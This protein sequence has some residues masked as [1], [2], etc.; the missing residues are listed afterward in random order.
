MK[1]VLLAC[2]QA[3]K[4]KLFENALRSLHYF[5]SVRIATSGKAAIEAMGSAVYDLALVAEDLGDIDTLEF[6]A[7]IRQTHGRIA[8][9]ALGAR[10]DEKAMIDACSAGAD[11]YL[12]YD[13]THETMDLGIRSALCGM[14]LIDCDTFAAC[15]G[16]KSQ[17][18][19]RQGLTE[20]DVSILRLVSEG[21]SNT[22]IASKLF[23]SENTIKYKVS[24]LMARFD[25]RSRVQ[26]AVYAVRNGII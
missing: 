14:M 13:A 3:S 9:I 2:G 15:L 11:G 18:S 1:R 17:S 26:L 24:A 5:S 7:F 6:I 19:D 20:H 12:P 22:D 16:L 4:A 21:L 23:Y 8:I 25:V 10:G